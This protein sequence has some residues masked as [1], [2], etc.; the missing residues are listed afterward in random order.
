MT[1]QGKKKKQARYENKYSYQYWKGVYKKNK[2]TADSLVCIA[3][4]GIGVILSIQL[5]KLT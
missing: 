1:C 5:A 2:F 3:F 4:F